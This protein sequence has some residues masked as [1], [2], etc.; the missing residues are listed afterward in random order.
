MNDYIPKAEQINVELTENV[1][2]SAFSSF[3]VHLGNC[4]VCPEGAVITC[5]QK[6]PDV[7]ICSVVIIN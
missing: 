5:L 1:E 3:P 7:L 4:V 6:A 2:V